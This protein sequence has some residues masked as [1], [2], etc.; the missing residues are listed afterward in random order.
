MYPAASR[1]REDLLK[2]SINSV[3]APN[4]SRDRN[5]TLENFPQQESFLAFGVIQ[6]L[7]RGEIIIDHYNVYIVHRELEITMIRTAAVATTTISMCCRGRR[8]IPVY[9]RSTIH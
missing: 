9:S 6:P 7:F 3:S 2:E 1:G 4:R 8:V 5:T